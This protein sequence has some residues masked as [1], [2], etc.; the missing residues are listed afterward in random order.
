LVDNAAERYAREA[1]LRFAIVR[2]SESAESVALY[3]GEPDE[4]RNLNSFLDAVLLST[5]RLSGA[6]ARPAMGG[7]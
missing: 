3:S 1:D 7:R 2:V 5:R 4:R 6:S